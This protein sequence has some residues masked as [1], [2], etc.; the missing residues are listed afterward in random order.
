VKIRMT[1]EWICYD[2]NKVE[3]LDW[4]FD[5]QMAWLALEAAENSRPY[6]PKS[7]YEVRAGVAHKLANGGIVSASGGN[8][9]PEILAAHGEQ[10]AAIS[11]LQSLPKEEERRI[12][13]IAF[14]TDKEPAP[15]TLCGMCRTNLAPF[16][17]KD[18]YIITGNPGTGEAMILLWDDYSPAEWEEFRPRRGRETIASR[19][20]QLAKPI[21][22]NVPIAGAWIDADGLPHYGIGLE[23]SSP[24][25]AEGPIASATYSLLA[26]SYAAPSRFQFFRRESLPKVSP[27]QI[28]FIAD[29]LKN[30]GYSGD[31]AAFPIERYALDP[32]GKPLK[33]ERTTLGAQLPYTFM[34][35]KS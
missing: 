32:L 28:Q 20:L 3:F 31:K 6:A 30:L 33:A 8:F 7:G 22:T 26:D 23:Y 17:T 16:L 15:A 18:S 29:S 19:E 27:A 35:V 24:E 11:L 9:E 13:A 25:R 1:K 14:V 12:D 10:I 5:G 2:E 4:S 34:S 21:Y